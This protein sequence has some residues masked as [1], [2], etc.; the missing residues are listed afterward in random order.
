MANPG[1]GFSET[2][3]GASSAMT[4]TRLA[5]F[6]DSWP[7]AAVA[8][9]DPGGRGSHDCSAAQE[10]TAVDPLR[11]RSHC[12]S[13]LVPLEAASYHAG[14]IGPGAGA[15]LWRGSAY[16]D[17]A[18]AHPLG[19]GVSLPHP[20]LFRRHVHA[21]T[22]QSENYRLVRWIMI[23]WCRLSG[24][25]RRAKTGCIPYTRRMR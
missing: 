16:P 4:S 6:P 19:A 14:P 23:L 25:G 24:S 7:A 9:S 1:P 3:W 17:G 21:R 20:Y 13:P 8:G 22:I 18:V 15:G 5:G 2:P 10:L 11:R 12:C